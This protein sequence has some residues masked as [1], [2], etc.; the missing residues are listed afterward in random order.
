MRTDNSSTR[1]P[2]H[3]RRAGAEEAR[4]LKLEKI[5]TLSRAIVQF[6]LVVIR[7]SESV[8]EDVQVVQEAANMQNTCGDTNWSSGS[9]LQKQFRSKISTT[10]V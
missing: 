7:G 6:R 3:Q 10:S 8:C 1:K 2:C 5:T 4:S 9:G